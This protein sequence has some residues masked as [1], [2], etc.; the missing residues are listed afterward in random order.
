LVKFHKALGYF[1]KKLKW[2]PSITYLHRRNIFLRNINLLAKCKNVLEIGCGSG[3]ILAEINRIYPKINT[4]SYDKSLKSKKLIQHFSPKSISLNQLEQL[5][6][7]MDCII[8]FE[9]MEHIENDHEFLN[10]IYRALTHN[11]FIFFSVPAHQSKWSVTDLWAGHYRRYEKNEIKKLIKKNNFN[12]ERF[13]SYGFP[14]CNI[15]HN[16]SKILKK[17]KA[18]KIKN[19][20]VLNED[21]G[22]DRNIEHVIFIFIR[23]FPLYLFINALLYFQMLFFKYDF[24]IGYFGIAKKITTKKNR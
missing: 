5:P 16:I 9:V 7:K 10:T 24:G 2:A 6:K 1:S 19:R 21:S 23:T 14:I 15:A 11:G 22:V 20:K 13:Y 8:F 17:Y 18:K 3:S 4:F 12:I